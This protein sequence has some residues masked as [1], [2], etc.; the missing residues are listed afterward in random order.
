MEGTTPQ[1][2]HLV[3]LRQLAQLLD[4]PIQWLAEEAKHGRIPRLV[5]TGPY[6]R[7]IYRFNLRAVEDCL[8]I[9]AALGDKP[10]AREDSP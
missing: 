3:T 4:L 2:N 7:K 8:A 9:R 1:D 5:A 6:R 10:P